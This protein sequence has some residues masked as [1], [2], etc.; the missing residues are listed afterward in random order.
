MQQTSIIFFTGSLNVTQL[1]EDTN[2]KF[3]VDNTGS[4]PYPNTELSH[5]C[6][7]QSVFTFIAVHS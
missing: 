6:I 2:R 7:R 4:R 5:T 1:E 3:K